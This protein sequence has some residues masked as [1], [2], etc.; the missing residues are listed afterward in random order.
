MTFRVILLLEPRQRLLDMQ[1]V[2]IS[3]KPDVRRRQPQLH[4][5]FQQGE[6][7]G[8]GDLGRLLKEP[9]QRPDLVGGREPGDAGRRRVRGRGVPRLDGL[10]HFAIHAGRTGHGPEA[11]TPSCCPSSMWRF[12][13][14]GPFKV[15][16]VASRWSDAA[17]AVPR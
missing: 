13:T 3:Q 4:D 6:V 11:V 16:A 2:H 1:V 9:G 14:A 12:S 15:Y 10:P 7:Q 8:P 17:Q 5:R